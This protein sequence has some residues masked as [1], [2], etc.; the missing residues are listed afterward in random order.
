MET[1]AQVREVALKYFADSPFTVYLLV[2][3][4]RDE[5]DILTTTAL[6]KE[7]GFE[8]NYFIPEDL[9][10]LKYNAIGRPLIDLPEDSLSVATLKAFVNN[11]L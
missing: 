4:I 7:H 10:L 1:V 9:T 8:V 2:N 5:N 6:A 3:R 11:E